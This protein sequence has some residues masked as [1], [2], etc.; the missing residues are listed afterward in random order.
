M[1]FYTG[2]ILLSNRNKMLDLVWEFVGSFERGRAQMTKGQLFQNTQ[3]RQP[4]NVCRKGFKL[5][6][7]SGNIDIITPV[8]CSNWVTKCLKCHYKI[9]L[10]NTIL[11]T[12]SFTF[13]CQTC[14]ICI[15]MLK[16]KFDNQFLKFCLCVHINGGNC[17]SAS[18]LL[19]LF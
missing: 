9:G 5:R 18:F 7:L 10:N 3:K 12:N 17:S 14:S 19:L 4:G 15:G 13:Y 1:H 16:Q 2:Q 11:P 8:Q 6:Y